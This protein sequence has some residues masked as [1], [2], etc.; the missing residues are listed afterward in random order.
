M[1]ELPDVE[2]FRNYLD[3]TSLNQSIQSVQLKSLKILKEISS[4]ELEK[5]LPG[6]KILGS[7]RHGKHLFLRMDDARWLMLHFGMTGFLKYFERMEEDPKHDR[8]LI[9]FENGFHLAYVCQRLLGEV[10]L[11]E[12]KDKLIQ[13]REMGRDALEMD[14]NT[15]KKIIQEKRGSI[16]SALMNQKYI[17]GIGNIYSDEILFQAGVH[18]KK[19]AKQLGEAKIKKI[20]Q[21]MR[22]VLTKA[23][24]YHVDPAQFPDSYMLPHRDTDLRCPRCHNSFQQIKITGRTAYVCP[25]CQE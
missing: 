1:P 9:N 24:E 5:E 15:F 17:S 25:H 7:H 18:P 16:K 8:M 12:D 11:V 2:V 10:N 21:E 3:S 6:R 14:Y 13:E 19:E 22:T 23:I 20:Y 4:Q